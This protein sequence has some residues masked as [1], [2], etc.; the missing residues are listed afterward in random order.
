[1]NR[2]VVFGGTTE[3]RRLCENAS[4]PILY[5]V[6]TEDGARVVEGLANVSV[7]IG[8]LDA[9]GMAALFEREKPSLVIDATHPYAKEASRN[10]A[11][12]SQRAGVPLEHVVR[13]TVTEPG[14]I[15][16]DGMEELLDW[17]AATPGNI[18]VTSGVSS[19][20]ALS[21]LPEF[22]S[23]VWLR[24]LP[25]WE[26]LCVCLG[27]GYR[28]ERLVCMQGPFS[29]ALNRAMFETADAKILVTKE[30][31]VAGGFSEKVRAARSLEMLIAVLK[32]PEMDA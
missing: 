25:N 27:A 24:V 15:Y 9:R 6:A 19:A 21:G 30:S 17:L 8:R 16:F 26:S 7:H 28:P 32:R 23:R 12:A 18:F 5:C 29:E 1:M 14:C 2:T 22:Q 13:E 4:V 11:L 3:G 31:G 10:I 20:K